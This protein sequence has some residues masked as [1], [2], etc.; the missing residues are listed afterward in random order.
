M[1]EGRQVENTKIQLEIRKLS[2]VHIRVD[3]C[4]QHKIGQGSLQRARADRCRSCS[5]EQRSRLQQHVGAQRS[6]SALKANKAPRQNE[7]LGVRSLRRD[8]EALPMHVKRA[9]EKQ[10]QQKVPPPCG[11]HFEASPHD[12]VTVVE[13]H[14]SGPG[15]PLPRTPTSSPPSKQSRNTLLPLEP[16]PSPHKERATHTGTQQTNKRNTPDVN[17][18]TNQTGFPSRLPPRSRFLSPG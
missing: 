17:N 3:L 14:P 10:P 16:I 2:I 11:E 7:K 5:V 9:S 18:F 4:R 6:A 1:H 15:R 13:A 8:K 12:G